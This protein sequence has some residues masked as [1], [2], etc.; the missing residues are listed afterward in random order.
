LADVPLDARVMSEEPFGPIATCMA[1]D[2]MDEALKIS[3]SLRM[4]LAAFVFTN[5]M[6]RADYLSREIQVGSVALNVFTSPGGDAP[7]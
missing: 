7:F 2:S 6:E 3:N 4:G 5:D 1:V